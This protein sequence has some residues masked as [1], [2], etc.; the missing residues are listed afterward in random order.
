MVLRLDARSAS[1]ARD[2]AALLTMK[3]EVSEDVD[4]AAK[5]IIEDVVARGDEA[6]VDYTR[7]FDRLSIDAA[8]L[9]VTSQEI[10]AAVAG[11]PADA[12]EALRLAHSRIEAY[13]VRQ[14]SRPTNGSSMPWASRWGTGGR[15]SRLRGCTSG[16]HGELS[17]SVLMN[18][19]PARVA[20]VPRIVMAVPTPTA[21]SIR[22]SSPPRGSPASTRS[23]ALAEPRRSPRSPTERRPSRPSPRSS[24]RKTL[25]SP[26]RSAGCSGRSGST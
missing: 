15:R 7:R 5:S 1:F 3:R 25:M 2:F 10:D 14:R 26:Q 19:I 18:A 23:I 20:G 24:G 12:L 13:H 21:C 8:R 4:A 17:S 11:S 6:L 9:R 22:S 16:R